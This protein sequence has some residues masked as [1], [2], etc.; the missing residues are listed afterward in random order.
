MGVAELGGAA[1]HVG[2]Q[3]REQRTFSQRIESGKPTRHALIKS[4]HGKF[5]DEML[6]SIVHRAKRQP[7]AVRNLII[8]STSLVDQSHVACMCNPSG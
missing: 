1:L 6:E 8:F 7:V 5:Q 3:R 2:N 4:F